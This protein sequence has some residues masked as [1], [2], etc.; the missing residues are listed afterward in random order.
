MKTSVETGMDSSEGTIAVEL[1]SVQNL[2]HHDTN[3]TPQA[4]QNTKNFKAGWRHLFVFAN[5]AH[6]G[7]ALAAL[8]ATAM[9]AGLKTVLSVVLGKVFDVIA[10]YGNGSLNSADTLSEISKWCLVLTG[11]GIGNWLASTAFLSLWI[12]FGELQASSVRHKTF[13]SLLSKNMTWFDSQTEGISSLLV[14]IQTQTRELQLAT[15]QVF[16]LL[17]CDILTSVASLALALYY[18]WKLTLVLLAT[19]PISAIVLSLATRRLEPAIQAQKR[20]LAT[21]SKYATASITAIDLVKV[22]NGYDQEV[23]QYFRAIKVAAKHYLVQAQCNALQMGYVA[24]WV[25]AMFVVGFW[26]GVVLVNDGLAPGAVLTTFYATLASFQGIEALMPHWIVLA[27]GMSAGA[28]LSSITSNSRTG[29]TIKAMT[30]TLRPNRCNGD[31]EL[32]DVSFA[33]PSNL[34]R[35]VLNKSSFF[36]PAGEMTFIV[37]R[38]GSGKSTL[39]NLM[40]GFYEPLTGE[41]QV[42]DHPLRILDKEWVQENVTLIQQSSILF[43]DT[44]FKNVAFGHPDPESATKSEVMG[45]CEAALL[46]STLAALPDGLD[47]NIGSGGYNLSGGQKQRMALARARLR[48]PPVLILDEIT[49]GL[50]QVSKV[51]VMEAIREWRHNKTTI[52]ITHDVSQ[53]GENDFVYVMDRA[54]LVQEGFKRDLARQ[55]SGTFATLAATTAL[56]P[57]DTPIEISVSSPDSLYPDSSSWAPAPAR[58]SRVSQYF[59]GELERS[60]L[61]PGGTGITHRTSLGVGTAYAMRM[62]TAQIWESETPPERPKSRAMSLAGPDDEKES[63]VR[64]LGKRLSLVNEKKP[65]IKTQRFSVQT[66]RSS[67]DILDSDVSFRNSMEDEPSYVFGGAHR[68][69]DISTLRTTLQADKMP[70][71]KENSLESTAQDLPPPMSLL[72]ILKTVWPAL[73]FRHRLVLVLGVIVCIIGAAATPAFSY[74]FAQL[75]GAMW[76]PGDK[77]AEGKKWAIYLIVI[78]VVDGLG[79]GGGRYLLECVAQAWVNTIRVEALKRILRQPKAWFDKSRNSPGRINECLDR[80]AEEMRNIV[81]RFIPIIIVV[82]VLIGMSVIWSLIVSWK[83]TLVSLAPLPVVMGAVKG[84]SIVSGKWEA[85]CNQGAEDTSAMLTEIFLNIRVVKALKLEKHFSGK[86]LQLVRDTLDTGLKR[87]GYTSWLFGLYQS[88]NYPLTALVFYYGTV[89]LAREQQ[90]TAT[91]VLQVVNLLLFSMGTSTGILSSIPQ[92]TMAQ[93]TATQMLTYASMSM[94]P[95]TETRGSRKPATPLPV[96]LQDVEFSYKAGTDRQVLRGVSLEVRTGDCLAIVGHSGCGKSTVI[97]LLLGLYAPPLPFNS[98]GV[99]PLTFSGVSF[100]DVDILHLRSMT[101]Y[102]PQTPFL[103]PTTIAENIAYGLNE[104]S[105][106]RHMR[107]LVNAAQ[108]AGLHE[109]IV[110]LPDGYNSIVGDGG[111]ALSGGQAQRLSIARALARKP[112]LLV[113]DEPTSALDAESAEMIRQTIQD[114]TTQSRRDHGGMAI[115]LVT[116]NKDMMRVADRIVV[117]EDG[118][119]VEEGTY[120]GLLQARG[121]FARLSTASKRRGRPLS[122]SSDEG[123]DAAL[124]ARRERNRQ[125]QNVFRKRRQAAEAAQGQRLRRLE[126]VVEEMSSVFMSFVDEMLQTEAVKKDSG[127]VGSLRRSTARILTLVNEVV[128][129]EEE[130]PNK[131]DEDPSQDHEDVRED[132]VLDAHVEA[133]MPETK[134]AASSAS[135]PSYS[136]PSS[137]PSAESVERDIMWEHEPSNQPLQLYSKAFEA[138][139]PLEVSILTGSPLPVSLDDLYTKP[140][141]LSPQIFGDG[142]STV[143]LPPPPPY[144]YAARAEDWDPQPPLAPESFAFRLAKASLATAY[145]VLSRTQHPPIP[146]SE[147]H[148]IFGSSLQYRSR[149]DLLVKLRWLLGPGT[150][151]IYRVA[152]MPYGRYGEHLFSRDD[153]SPEFDGLKTPDIPPAGQSPA[154]TRFLSVVGVEKQL[155]ALGARIVDAE[156]LELNINSPAPH[157]FEP[158]E[159]VAAQSESWSFVDFFSPDQLRPKPNVLTMRLSM[160]QLVTNLS[161]RAVC[162]MRGP[163]FPRDELAGAIEASIITAAGG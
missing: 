120:L 96:R 40:V 78:A 134:M 117:L 76:S 9:T 107:N 32:T 69:K 47:T 162:L 43:N 30:G 123:G 88:I 158:S 152:N 140:P 44:F 66:R 45:A 127:L 141:P 154:V 119:K 70:P 39:G 80:N 129:P 61:H 8:V 124:K 148:R 81:G 153:L 16:G 24:F 67:F 46:Q 42:D 73:G 6:V 139:T 133:E 128:G 14:R 94:K 161:Q 136:S 71:T 111:Q 160:S 20:E 64:T 36:F 126:E 101:A 131:V 109:F 90:I 57:A 5:K 159:P 25:V 92:I 1:S 97:S 35:N 149:E 58:A 132:M 75:L 62:K 138:K 37:G 142:W 147:E 79:T 104:N 4:T 23:W 19:L 51:L 18:S 163:G 26:Y 156:T 98:R 85:S 74:C 151:D 77:L 105:P 11:L 89:L 50:D 91:A 7:P 122:H 102:V 22:F 3:T 116:H 60:A 121:P 155:L 150:Q 29:R 99:S 59:V 33:Y 72:V 137:L 38:S 144:P 143:R 13:K 86:Y 10:K 48:D 84:Y 34:R 56:E 65:T 135:P 41:V 31:V 115:V 130:D 95:S 113:L 118:A 106:L 54:S 2:N 21:A 17:V 27:K 15:S 49:S 53:I 28:F 55:S 63:M 100:A 83:L 103:F 157:D 125:A 82:T 93:A 145:L 52:I 114:L 110:S 12:V 87:A 146:L 68:R 112:L 108:A